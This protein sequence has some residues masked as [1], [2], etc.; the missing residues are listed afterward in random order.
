MHFRTFGPVPRPACV[1][2]V[3]AMRVVLAILAWATITAPTA[4]AQTT[5]VAVQ[6][7]DGPAPGARSMASFARWYSQGAEA[8]V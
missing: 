4:A 8:P 7:G 2:L 1:V 5:A 3:Q 6:V